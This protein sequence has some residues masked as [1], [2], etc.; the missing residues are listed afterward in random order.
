[1]KPPIGKTFWIYKPIRHY[2][3]SQKWLSCSF[4]G[5]AY[6]NYNDFSEES[7]SLNTPPPPQLHMGGEGGGRWVDMEILNN[8]GKGGWKNLHINGWVK[9]NGGGGGYSIPK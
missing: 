9:H 8:G 2:V 1:M 6:N 5:K 3:M 7:H 4:V